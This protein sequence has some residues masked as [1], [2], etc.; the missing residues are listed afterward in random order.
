MCLRLSHPDECRPQCTHANTHKVEIKWCFAF[1]QG[2]K[3]QDIKF[4]RAP[5]IASRTRGAQA[6][7]VAVYCASLYTQQE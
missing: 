7:N 5:G 2:N 1:A 3:A 6:A 4:L